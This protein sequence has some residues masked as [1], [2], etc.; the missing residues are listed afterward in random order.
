MASILDSQLIGTDKSLLTQ[1]V[2]GV[3]CY[4]ALA[5]GPGDPG[6]VTTTLSI[7][8]ATI[9]T[10]FSGDITEYG[11]DTAGLRALFLGWHPNGIAH[12]LNT[13]ECAIGIW[14]VTFPTAGSYTA[15]LSTIGGSASLTAA[16]AA[17]AAPAVTVT[18]LRQGFLEN[19]IIARVRLSFSGTYPSGGLTLK[20]GTTGANLPLLLPHFGHIYDTALYRFSWDRAT[21]KLQVYDSAGE[22]S[23]VISFTTEALFQ[24]DGL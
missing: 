11:L 7:V 1:A 24:G 23:G 5:W 18:P 10:S 6:A 8:G 2:E 19:L 9:D 20:G 17:V 3:A 21:E 14:K 12:Y 22:A 4:L 13:W 16:V 15:L